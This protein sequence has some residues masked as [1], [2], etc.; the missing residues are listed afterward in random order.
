MNDYAVDF[1]SWMITAKNAE[2]SAATAVK[3]LKNG[4]YP[5]IDKVVLINED[6]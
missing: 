6:V 4:K 2:E 3:M 1:G 5:A